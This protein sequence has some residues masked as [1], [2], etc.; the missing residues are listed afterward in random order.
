MD[1]DVSTMSREA[2]IEEIRKLRQGRRQRRH[3]CGNEPCW[4]QNAPWRFVQETNDLVR[5]E[6]EWPEFM[7]GCAQ[8]RQLLDEQAADAPITREP[9]QKSE[10]DERRQ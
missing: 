2:L 10:I 5:V 3:R 6:P 8:C 9:C 7:R 1:K 4:H